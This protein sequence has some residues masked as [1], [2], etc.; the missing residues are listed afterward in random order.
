M[1][2]DWRKKD[3]FLLLN[4]ILI[5]AKQYVYYD[6]DVEIIKSQHLKFFYHESNLCIN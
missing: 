2:G 1:F 3:D 6:N 5:I 4:Q